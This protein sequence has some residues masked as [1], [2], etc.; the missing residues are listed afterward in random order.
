LTQSVNG[1]LKIVSKYWTPKEMAA[2]RISQTVDTAHNGRSNCVMIVRT[3]YNQLH[4]IIGVIN[5]KDLTEIPL[6]PMKRCVHEN[7]HT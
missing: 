2:I 7:K 1:A 3:K 4:I 5:D 6:F